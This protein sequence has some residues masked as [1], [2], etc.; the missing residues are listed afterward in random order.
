MVTEHAQGRNLRI[1][2]TRLRQPLGLV[3]LAI[4]GAIPTQQEHIRLRGR[5]REQVPAILLEGSWGNGDPRGLRY[6]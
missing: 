1:G 4:I 2:D 5:L 3:G 6:V